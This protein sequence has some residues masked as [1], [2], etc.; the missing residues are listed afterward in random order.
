MFTTA[1]NLIPCLEQLLLLIPPKHVTLV[2]AGNGQGAL[3]QWLSK[4]EN[5]ITL[6]EALEQN[7]KALQNQKKNGALLNAKLENRVVAPL[8]GSSQFFVHSI[9]AE[10]GLLSVTHLKKLWPN[11]ELVSS[12]PSK[13][14]QLVHFL[15]EEFDHQWLFIDCLPAASLIQSCAP[16]ILSKVD[17]VLVR[18]V[19]SA[20]RDEHLAGAYLDEVTGVLPGFI[21]CVLQPSIH[22][23]IYYALFVRDYLEENDKLSKEL[24]SAVSNEDFYKKALIEKKALLDDLLEK[25]KEL[26]EKVDSQDK[27][28]C[29]LQSELELISKIRDQE[30]EI[31]ART[32][33]YYGCIK[34]QLQTLI[35]Q[36]TEIQDQFKKQGEELIRLRKFLDA[37]FKKEISNASRQIQAFTG[38]EN[39]WKNGDLPTANTENHAW[40]ISPDFALYLVRLL[41]NNNYD[42]V[43][44]FGS[45]VSTLVI[46]KALSKLTTKRVDR[47]PVVFASFDHLSEYYCQTLEMLNQ[48]KLGD[49]VQL[50]LAPL[51]DWKAPNGSTY[52]YYDC[53]EVLASL[54][55]V[56]ST[57]DLRILVVV[58][59]PPAATGKHARYPAGPIVLEQF[60]GAQID[61]LMDDFIREDEKEIVQLWQQ[62]MVALNIPNK[63]TVKKLEKDACLL[64]VST[65][66]LKSGNSED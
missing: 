50:T 43:I 44:E 45:G 16:S 57:N 21:Q 30:N 62:E 13:A 8:A 42:L 15:N 2:G 28:R 4:L 9:A 47:S 64:Q 3:V 22:P 58:D 60:A 34:E 63:S 24:H 11:L 33:E 52:S 6:V 14:V 39:Y 5:S 51:K 19:V 31:N 25:N 26:A 41:E 49:Y 66:L 53:Q 59:G 56:L 32:V 65:Q 20:D 48:A 37:S 40:P 29:E 17:V 55:K 61:W 35:S 23:E 10:N 36:K 27:I 54:S 18:A 1:R 46:A 38:L 12:M 7:F